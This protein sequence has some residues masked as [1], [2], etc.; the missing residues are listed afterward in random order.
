MKYFI[1]S[2]DSANTDAA[3]RTCDNQ[4][5]LLR[6]LLALA[7]EMLPR[8]AVDCGVHDAHPSYGDTYCDCK[9]RSLR[10]NCR[11]LLSKGSK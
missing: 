4:E 5:I 2:P 10:K 9:M 8:H 7:V 6:T 11:E 1:D 3:A